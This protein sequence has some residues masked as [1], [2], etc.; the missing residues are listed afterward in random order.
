MEASAT[1]DPSGIVLQWRGA[2]DASNYIIHKRSRLDEGWIEVARLGGDATAWRDSSA[3]PGT[4][5]EYRIHK[6]TS[7]PYAGFSFVYAGSEVPATH[8]RG[9]VILVVESSV[10]GSLGTELQR[11]KDDLAGDGWIVRQLSVGSGDSPQSVRDRIR[12]NYD[13]DR[14]NTKA[15]SSSV[16]CQVPY[17][18]NIAPDGHEN[19][20]GAWPADVFYGE[21]DG[22]WTDHEVN[23]ETA[24]REINRNRPGD[25]KFDQSTIPGAVELAVG[26]VDFFEMTCYANKNPARSELDL[27]RAYFAKN[28]EF[29]QGRITVNRK[30]LIVDNFGL[31][32]T[33]AVSANGWRNF[34]DSLAWK[35]S[36]NSGSTPT[37]RRWRAIPH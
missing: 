16:M 29:R 27:L 34:R 8:L 20:R 7:G 9:K 31:R 24:E 33:N 37:F 35:T 22:S 26:R 17:S 25:G 32:G 2:S 6:V 18:G 36:L 5:Y 28:H 30:G 19:H 13:Q 10:A 21:L 12:S 11:L 4:A 15:V 14:V 3:G 23:S 1:A